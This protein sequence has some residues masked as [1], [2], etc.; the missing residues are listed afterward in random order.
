MVNHYK[1][2]TQ[3]PETP[4]SA[5]F[6]HWLMDN[7]STEFMEANINLAISCVQGQRL[8]GYIGNTGVESWQGTLRSHGP[9]ID[10]DGIAVELEYSLGSLATESEDFLTISIVPDAVMPE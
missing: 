3:S 4:A 7:T 6:C 9:R 2:C 1:T 10:V 8:S 5:K